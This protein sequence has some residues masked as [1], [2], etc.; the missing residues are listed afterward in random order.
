MWWLFAIYLITIP[1]FN[2]F[3]N[4][5]LTENDLVTIDN[6]ILSKNAEKDPGGGK[7][8]RPSL[9]FRFTATERG[10]LF[11]GEEYSCVNDNDILKN[12]K[13]GDTVSIKL[14]KSDKDKFS[15]ANWFIKFTKIYGLSKDGKEYL[16]LACRN[17]VSNRWS[18]AATMASITSAVLSLIF[19]VFILRPKTKYQALRGLS[20]DPIFIVLVAWLA[21]FLMLR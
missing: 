20:I 16:S 14:K 7:Y 6:L 15:N 12:F 2:L 17:K 8:S 11:S 1:L 10:F 9:Q 21:V 18:H 4:D 13:M 19:A 3:D 5:Q